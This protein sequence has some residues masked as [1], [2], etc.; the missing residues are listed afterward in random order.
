MSCFAGGSDRI[1]EHRGH[2]RWL[3]WPVV[4]HQVLQRAAFDAI[5]T[6]RCAPF[7]GEMTASRAGEPQRSVRAGAHA[8]AAAEADPV[9]HACLLQLRPA[10]VVGGHHPDRLDRARDGA[11]AAAGTRGRVD[12]GSQ[13]VVWIG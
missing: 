3:A 9:V 6:A 4:E 2:G 7:T 1:R 13:F 5:R 8:D 11:R 12:L 10:R